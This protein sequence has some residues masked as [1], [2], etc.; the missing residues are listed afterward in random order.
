VLLGLYSLTL[1]WVEFSGLCREIKKTVGAKLNANL[2]AKKPWQRG[3]LAMG[4]G[5][6]LLW[7][8]GKGR[9]LSMTNPCS[10]TSS[11]K[12]HIDAR[13]LVLDTS[14]L[15]EQV[16]QIPTNQIPFDTK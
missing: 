5:M 8:F 16:T 14:V 12:T 2:V 1:C 6:L 10:Q 13:E 15:L 7:H 11:S 3:T 9:G 4:S